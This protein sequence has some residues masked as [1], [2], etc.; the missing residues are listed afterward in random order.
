MSRPCQGLFKSALLSGYKTYQLISLEMGIRFFVCL[1]FVFSRH[2]FSCSLGCP[3]TCSAGQAGFEL[4]PSA[5]ASQ[6]GDGYQKSEH[7]FVAVLKL[8][9]MLC[10][11]FLHVDHMVKI[12]TV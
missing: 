4:D 12:F 6:V 11:F 2:G 8:S 1:I 3:G 5:S 9:V 10:L 7:A